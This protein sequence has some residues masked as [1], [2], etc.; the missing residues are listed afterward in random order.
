MEGTKPDKY[1]R[2]PFKWTDDM[3]SEYQTYWIIPKYN[4]P[5]SRISY[6]NK[7]KKTK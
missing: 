6:R 5:N 2:E 1:I 7:A 3:R 4:I